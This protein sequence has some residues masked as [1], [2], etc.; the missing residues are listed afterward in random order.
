MATSFGA[1]TFS[2]LKR[3]KAMAHG[4]K[5]EVDSVDEDDPRYQWP[6][7]SK[8]ATMGGMSKRTLENMVRKGEARYVYDASGERHFDPEWLQEQSGTV[9]DKELD[10]D[11]TK[12]TFELLARSNKDLQKFSSELL[13]LVPSAQYR[14]NRLLRIENKALR[15]HNEKLQAKYLQAIEA[16]ESALTLSH[17]RELQRMQAQANEE[18]KSK[19]FDTLMGQVPNL[20]AQISFKQAIDKF[21]GSF[22]PDQYEVLFELMTEEQKALFGTIMKQRTVASKTSNGN[23]SHSTSQEWSDDNN[24]EDKAS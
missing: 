24:S 19:G 12:E 9:S 6:K 18:R 21:M 3:G 22:T 13:K 10:N 1:L 14:T 11:L 8:A 5:D 20:I 16:F 4:T 23:G 15:A 2:K 7:T 17:E